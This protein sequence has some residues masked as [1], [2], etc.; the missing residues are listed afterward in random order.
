MNYLGSGKLGEYLADV[1][2][3][4]VQR[5]VLVVGRRLK[6]MTLRDWM[7]VRGSTC[8]FL[9]T[10]DLQGWQNARS[11]SNASKKSRQIFLALIPPSPDQAR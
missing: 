8:I 10:I 7:A 2:I 1:M 6:N 11:I 5:R 3:E 9:D 4:G